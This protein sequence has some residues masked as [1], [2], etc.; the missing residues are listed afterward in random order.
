[1]SPRI[2]VIGAGFAGLAAAHRLTKLGAE[3]SVLEAR[4][5]V[6]GRVWSTTVTAP[7]GSEH[8]IERGAEYVLNGYDHLRAILAELGLEQVDTGMSYYVREPGDLPGR[9]A[10]DIVEA[11]RAAGAAI[12]R[13]PAD[14]SAEDV[15]A[16]LAADGTPAELVD[17][18]RSR[19]EVSTAVP[20]ATVTAE[21][22]AHV[23]SFEPLPSYR[24]GGGNQR[25]ALGLTELLGSKVRLN[26][27]VSS[28]EN[29]AHGVRLTLADG[30]V[31][32]YDAAIV[33]VPLALLQ[34]ED[35]LA[36]PT[37]P[38][39]EQALSRVLLG[40]AAKLHVALGSRPS[41]SAVMSVAGR[42]WTWTAYAQDGQV[43]PVLN[44]FMGSAPAIAAARLVEDPQAWAPEVAAL[45]PD[46]DIAPDAVPTVTVW[47]E[48]PWARFAY[49]AHAPGETPVD[50]AAIEAPIG[51]VY[52]AGE[53]AEAEFT[54][55][56]E[57]AIRS[58]ERAAES[59]M[60]AASA[61]AGA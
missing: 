51:A 30:T 19:I 38:E 34:A 9:T 44:A 49:A 50:A 46:L 10:Q 6:G 22:L 32:E 40:Q 21:S 5:R 23:A 55:L 26:T 54:G 59:V 18:L 56:M 41:T 3:V 53:Y 25:L 16:L 43:A 60:A 35:G 45:R 24:I 2:A 20:A 4:D 1:M 14:A 28:V 15:L 52:F 36:A 39:R 17:A 37:S 29:D 27:P 8:V 11:G 42:Y 57:G 12:E 7:D 48:D 58:G 47:A 61:K 13:V 33:A 31:E